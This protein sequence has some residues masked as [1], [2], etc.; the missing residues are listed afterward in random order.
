MSFSHCFFFDNLTLLSY[1]EVEGNNILYC[2][3]TCSHSENCALSITE[4]LLFVHD[5]QQV[6]EHSVHIEQGVLLFLQQVSIS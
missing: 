5:T 3:L 2:L 1:E 6:L 4:I